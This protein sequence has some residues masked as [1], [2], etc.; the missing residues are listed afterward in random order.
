MSNVDFVPEEYKTRKESNRANIICLFLFMVIMGGIAATFS[1]IKVRQKAVQRDLDIVTKKMDQAEQQIKQLEMIADRRS[2]MMKTA[3]LAGSLME[4]IPRS[5]LLA[6]LTNNLPPSASLIEI[7]LETDEKTKSVPLT[8]EELKEIAKSKD[9]KKNK[10]TVKTITVT[11]NLIEIQGLATTDIDVAN[12]IA[13]L[14]DS[15]LLVGVGLVESKE[16]DV[17]GI[18]YRQFKLCALLNNDVELTKED[19]DKIRSKNKRDPLNVENKGNFLSRFLK[20]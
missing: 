18:K 11:E 7:K 9:K 12:Y 1:V 5:I 20:G 15:I 16:F 6:C 4:P 17:E 13:S 8:E 2:R 14:T 10:Q 3:D 19:I